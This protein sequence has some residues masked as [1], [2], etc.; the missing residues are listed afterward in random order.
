LKA[1]RNVSIKK[2][3]D[4]MSKYIIKNID[5]ILIEDVLKDLEHILYNKIRKEYFYNYEVSDNELQCLN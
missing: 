1:Y 5:N 2:R 3:T 4:S